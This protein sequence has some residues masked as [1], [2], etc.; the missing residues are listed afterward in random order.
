MT[1]ARET[2]GSEPVHEARGMGLETGREAIIAR[3]GQR[4]AR[5]E[6]DAMQDKEEM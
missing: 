4:G 5:R 1:E 3:M 2:A 6:D